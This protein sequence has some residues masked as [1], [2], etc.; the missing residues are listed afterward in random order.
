MTGIDVNK[1]GVYTFF[2]SNSCAAYDNKLLSSVGGFKTVLISED[3]LAVF[4]LLKAGYRIIYVSDAVVK[5]SHS[6]KLSMEFKRYFDTGYMRGMFPKIQQAVGQAENRG[7]NYS[8]AFIKSVYK[9]KI[10]LI[11]YALVIL[12]FKWIG[13]RKI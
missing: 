8:I 4:D 7:I 5:H 1:Y 13:Y 11:P 9:T 3:Y 10:L 6:Y 2:C 12:I